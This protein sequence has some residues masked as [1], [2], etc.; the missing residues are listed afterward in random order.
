MYMVLALLVSLEIW[1]KYGLIGKRVPWVTTSGG[2]LQQQHSRVRFRGQSRFSVGCHT[3][4]HKFTMKWMARCLAGA[5]DGASDVVV[6]ANSTSL[7]NIGP[8]R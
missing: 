8:W 1:T 4:S 7:N 6:I 2:T 3:F 5:I